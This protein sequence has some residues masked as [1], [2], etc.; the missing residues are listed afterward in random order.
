MPAAKR[1]R[2]MKIDPVIKLDRIVLR[3]I[4]ESRYA[5]ARF[6]MQ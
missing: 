2:Q 5:A 6:S 3:A 1:L 4:E